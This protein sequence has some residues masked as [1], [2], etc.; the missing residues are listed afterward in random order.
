MALQVN[1]VGRVFENTD[2]RASRDAAS[3]SDALISDWTL[4]CR[5]S[6]WPTSWEVESG[7]RGALGSRL[8]GGAEGSLR[9]AW[10][11]GSIRRRRLRRRRSAAAS[12]ADEK[13][14]VRCGIGG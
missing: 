11:G 1:T 10:R 3:R 6:R 13:A 5:L 9:R 7:S 14:M 12:S 4:L 8:G 2:W